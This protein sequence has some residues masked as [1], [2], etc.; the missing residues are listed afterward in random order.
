VIHPENVPLSDHAAG[1]A[2]V[3]M[4]G[5]EQTVTPNPAG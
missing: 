3:T 1:K 2:L 4:G 5:V